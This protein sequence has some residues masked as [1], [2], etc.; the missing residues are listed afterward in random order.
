MLE[1][2]LGY[3]TDQSRLTQFKAAVTQLVKPGDVVA[4]LGCGTGI[5]GL[6]CLE[7][8]AGKVYEIDFGNV[9]EIA[10]GALSQ[11]EVEGRVTFIRGNSR[12][13][14]LPEKVDIVICDHVGC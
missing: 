2:H 8:G 11:A 12:R 1:E 4:D 7:A 13:L 6:L 10:R 9:L 3:V 14:D 5:L